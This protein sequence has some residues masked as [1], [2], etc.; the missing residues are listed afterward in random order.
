MIAPVPACRLLVPVTVRPLPVDWVIAP[1]LLVAS[2][3][4]VTVPLPRFSAPVLVAVR[5]PVVRVPRVSAPLSVIRVAPLLRVTAPVNWLPASVSASVWPASEKVLVPPTVTAPD[6]V[7]PMV[8]DTLRLPSASTAPRSAMRLLPV[9]L[10][11]PLVW[12]NRVPAVNAP[13]C[14][15]LPLVE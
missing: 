9:K 11:L 7:R 8:L 6:W 13:V 5:L 2:S 12:L 4:P 1:L 14:S 3:V 15:T 10:A